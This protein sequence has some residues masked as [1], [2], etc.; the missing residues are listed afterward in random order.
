MAAAS[1]HTHK[2]SNVSSTP[3]SEPTSEPIYQNQVNM[4][5][6]S[7][8]STTI[9]FSRQIVI[10][11]LFKL[12]VGWIKKATTTFGQKG[13]YLPKF[14]CSWKNALKRTSTTTTGK[15]HALKKDRKNNFK[16]FS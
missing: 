8:I 6:F 10:M 1:S 11:Q 5:F 13:A 16:F 7:A 9:F 12:F 14:T 3:G 2:Y 4:Y 15:K